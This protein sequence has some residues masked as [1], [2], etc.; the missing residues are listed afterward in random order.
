M[1]S[2]LLN[3]LRLPCGRD[4]VDCGKNYDTAIV[5]SKDS[6]AKNCENVLRGAR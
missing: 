4:T 6:V 3:G 1:R 5:D 2:P